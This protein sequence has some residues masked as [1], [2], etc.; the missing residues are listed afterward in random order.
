MAEICRV[1]LVLEDLDDGDV[2]GKMVFTHHEHLNSGELEA[3]S[4]PRI[5]GITVWRAGGDKR[6]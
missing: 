3:I 2:P 6:R 1:W 5:S 4:L